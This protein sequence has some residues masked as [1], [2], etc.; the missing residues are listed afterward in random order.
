MTA[1]SML[2]VSMVVTGGSAMPAPRFDEHRILQNHVFCPSGHMPEAIVKG[3]RSSFFAV[4]RMRVTGAL[5][6]LEGS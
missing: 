1:V 5:S 6:D 4:L 3:V 2:P